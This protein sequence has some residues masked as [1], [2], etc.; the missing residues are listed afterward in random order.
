MSVIILIKFFSLEN[1]LRSMVKKKLI[2]EIN[3]NNV[4]KILILLGHD[5]ITISII[6]LIIFFFLKKICII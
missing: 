4:R 6:I 3:R 1:L 5:L 2:F